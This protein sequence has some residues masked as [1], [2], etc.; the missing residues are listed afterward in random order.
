MVLEVLGPCRA[1]NGGVG[2]PPGALQ[3]LPRRR[4]LSQAVDGT[5]R[6]GE[7]LGI[8]L[9]INGAGFTLVRPDPLHH[10]QRQERKVQ[11]LTE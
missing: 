2:L 9:G 7:R 6:G 10:Q 1:Q 5:G 4:G 3:L 11:H 8:E